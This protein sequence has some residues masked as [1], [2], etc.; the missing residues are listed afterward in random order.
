ME[1]SL[2]TYNTLLNDGQ[3]GLK[4]IFNIHKPDF[5]CLQ[6]IDT[7]DK[8]LNN[9]E[10]L[11]YRLADYSNA[12]IKFGHVYGVATFFNEERF[13]CI[14]SKIISL[15]KGFLEIVSY[16]LRVFR[17][18]KKTR[19]VLKTEFVVKNDFL[20]IEIYNIHLSA[21]GTNGIRIKQL[22]K[23][24]SDINLNST[25][26]MIL[27]GDFNYA[28]G[29]RKLEEIMGGFGFNEATNTI[30]YTSD[31]KLIHYTFVE[32]IFAQIRN[33]LFHNRLKLDYVFCKNCKAIS[34]KTIDVPFSDH[35]PVFTKFKLS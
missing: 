18:G 35:F 13:A 3:E 23:T 31:G 24:L 33:K 4:K 17:S 2:L 25:Q 11:G 21:H 12:F 20:K 14:D 15:P 1:F 19:T 8:T 27:V 22:R 5:I 28:Y 32:K 26:P 6:E 34:S 16:V 9:I 29:R 7:S 30:S 10:K